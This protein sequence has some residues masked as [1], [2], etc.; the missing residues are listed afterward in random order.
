MHDI[1]KAATV[2]KIMVDDCNY[3]GIRSID[4]HPALHYLLFL[5]RQVPNP[6]TLRE[7]ERTHDYEMDEEK[8]CDRAL[9]EMTFTPKRP[10][11]A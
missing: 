5:A 1:D 3:D 10:T 6:P 9:L 4:G 2:L 7:F 8:Y 11:A